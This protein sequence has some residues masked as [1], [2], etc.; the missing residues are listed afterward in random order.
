ML[1][2]HVVLQIDS[3]YS[4]LAVFSVCL[5]TS[6]RLK[7]IFIPIFRGRYWFIS[8]V[9]RKI[10]H[11]VCLDIAE[12][13]AYIDKCHFYYK[14][15]KNITL[16]SQINLIYLNLRT[17]PKFYRDTFSLEM[18]HKIIKFV[19]KF[20]NGVFGIDVPNWNWCKCNPC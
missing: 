8:T 16:T 4:I 10:F 6:K 17:M 13:S 2:C 15:G 5:N 11:L 3:V 12:V 20:L 19:N 7:M 9:W 14:W 1:K 18:H